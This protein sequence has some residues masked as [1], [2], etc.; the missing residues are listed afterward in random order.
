MH[1][2]LPAT[3]HEAEVTDLMLEQHP[4]DEQCSDVL[5]FPMELQNERRHTFNHPAG[6]SWKLTTAASV[7]LSDSPC[8]PWTS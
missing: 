5:L 4:V 3:L 2:L 7:L 8:F 1:V 6:D